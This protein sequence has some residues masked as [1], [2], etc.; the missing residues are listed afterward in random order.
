LVPDPNSF[1]VSIGWP[2]DRGERHAVSHYLLTGCCVGAELFPVVPLRSPIHCHSGA[3]FRLSLVA[4]RETVV[5]LLLSCAMRSDAKLTA[6]SRSPI[7][8]K[9]PTPITTATTFPSLLRTSSLIFPTD[10]LASFTTVVPISLLAPIS[11]PRSVSHS[12]SAPD[13]HL[14]P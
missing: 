13:V 2:E 7:P 8:R 11:L 9:P 3:A 4:L 1:L 10:S 14:L 5:L 12:C 6:T